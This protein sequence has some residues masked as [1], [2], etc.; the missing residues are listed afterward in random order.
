MENNH[1]VPEFV[2]LEKMNFFNY[3]DRSIT[4]I[5]QFLHFILES[6]APLHELHERDA[7]SVRVNAIQVLVVLVHLIFCYRRGIARRYSASYF[8]LI[9]FKREVLNLIA[10]QAAILIGISLSKSEV[11]LSHEL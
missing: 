2:Y 9:L 5:D 6:L 11:Q 4:S 3:D 10:R 7:L 8:V 1:F